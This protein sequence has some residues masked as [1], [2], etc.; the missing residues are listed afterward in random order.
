MNSVLHSSKANTCTTVDAQLSDAK[1]SDS[2]EPATTGDFPAIRAIVEGTAGSTGE[3]FFRNL[4]RHLAA[5]TDAHHAF[6]AEFAD[7]NTRVRTLALT[8]P[9][10]YS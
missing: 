3:E 10:S 4:V 2:Q 7:V 9:R 6:V 8:G 1:R 5:A